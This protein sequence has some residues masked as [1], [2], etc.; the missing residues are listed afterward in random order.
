[1]TRRRSSIPTSKA[2]AAR[3][4]VSG[5]RLLNSEFWI[6]LLTAALPLSA[7][8]VFLKARAGAYLSMDLFPM[9]FAVSVAAIGLASLVLFRRASLTPWRIGCVVLATALGGLAFKSHFDF[10]TAQRMARERAGM[11]LL[12]GRPAPPLVFDQA[13]Q[14]DPSRREIVER[15]NGP[16]I[17]LDF[18]ATWCNPCLK[19]MP[20]LEA[21]Q[22]EHPEALLVVGVTRLY[23]ASD[24]REAELAR[25]REFADRTGVTYP[26]LV[27]GDQS[28]SAYGIGAL[29][30]SVLVDTDGTVA[31]YGVGIDGAGRVLKELRRRLE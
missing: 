28:W 10:K 24:A 6:L 26:I 3:F 13:Y 16:L 4:R 19:V 27:G 5:Y 25:I 15:M 7:V 1:M 20:E 18:W 12:E 22:R 9:V 29:P 17:L 21:L 8:F 14:I 23:D 30:T 2:R 11:E 31:D